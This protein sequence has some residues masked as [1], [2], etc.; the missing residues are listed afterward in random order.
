M[1]KS[2][3]VSLMLIVAL[4][5]VASQ[6]E[7]RITTVT[8][9][10]VKQL[11]TRNHLYKPVAEPMKVQADAAAMV[12]ENAIEVPF[13]HALGKNSAQVDIVKNYTVINNSTTGGWKLATVNDYSACMITSKDTEDKDDWLITVPVHMT[14][15]NYTL[16]YELGFMGTGSPTGVTMEVKLGTTPTI[17]GMTAE[18]VPSTVYDEKGKT[19]YKYNCVIPEDGYYYIGFHCIS[20]LA[21]KGTLKLYTVGVKPGAFVQVDPPAA[22]ELSWELAPKGEL[23]AT[24]TYVAPTKT[25]SGADLNEISK[26]V[27]TSLGEEESF[28]Y[29]NVK[30]GQT[31]VIEDVKMRAGLNNRLTALAYLGDTPGDIVEHKNIWC[32]PDTP[33]APTNVKLV[34]SDDYK[35]AVLSWDAPGEVGENGGYVDV[36]NLEYYV[37]DA[38]GNYYD[39]ALFSTDITSVRLEYSDLIGQD[40]V[41]YQVTAGYGEKYSLDCASNIATIGVPEVMPF[42]ESF[43]NCNYENRWLIDPKTS[44]G[45]QSYSIIDDSY[46]ESIIDP[47]D[48]EA[49]KPLKSQDGDNGFYFWMP[50]EKNDMMGLISVRTDISKAVNPVL[51]FWYQGQGSTLDVLLGRDVE[52][53]KVIKSIDLMAEPTSDWTLASMSLS[54]FKNMGAVMVELRLTAAHNDEEHTWSVPFDNISIRDL[55]DVDMRLVTAS[56]DDKVKV[57]E[58]LNVSARFQS[59]GRQASKAMAEC[60]VNGVKVGEVS[61]GEIEPYAFAEAQFAYTV[62][63]NA[64]E[65][66]DVKIVAVADGDMEESNNSFSRMVSVQHSSHPSVD[67]LEASA[68]EDGSSVTL[69]WSAPDI[70]SALESEIVFEDFENDDYQPMSISGVGE[71]TVYDGDKGKTYNV[72]REVYNPYQT[73]PIAFQLFNREIAGVSEYYED[74][75]PHSGNAFMMAPST[76]GL[77]DNWLISPELSGRKQ[78]VTLWMKSTMIMWPETVEILYSTGDNLIGSF[79]GQV[80]I[81][82]FL[83]NGVVPE[84][85]TKFEIQLP[86]G[87]KYFAIHHNSYDT[88]ALLVDDITYEAVSMLPADTKLIGYYIFRDNVLLNETPIENTQYVDNIEPSNEKVTT[89]YTYQVIAA[90]NNGTSRGANVS[91]GVESAGIEEISVDDLSENDRLYNLGGILVPIEK[92]TSG[93]YIRVNA[94]KAEKVAIK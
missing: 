85:W 88:L 89:T 94:D 16:S 18:I 42:T 33:L 32:G 90:Y 30:P 79:T 13:T 93:I 78:T 15:G 27:I 25:M 56:I 44:Y 62:P 80:D 9:G 55:V 87:A 22:G 34:A 45:Y 17:E 12:P 48:P 4:M 7:R 11:N 29:D 40:F 39:P 74:A 71:W 63:M 58:K 38:F 31:I 24:V 35:T 75:A 49:P 60:Y 73:Q 91:V 6:P 65:M 5:A 43:A 36:D 67:A 14:A 2:L 86:E 77:N 70:S 1:Q 57:G 61:L 23:K 54:E 66:L 52:E 3:L 28:N 46:F 53:L 10:A 76:E 21:Q 47:N 51:E 37:F 59:L 68:S 84:V 81:E 20:K 82:A 41:A 83:E 8:T 64:G 92:V 72:F 26:V 69:T 50:F 19:M